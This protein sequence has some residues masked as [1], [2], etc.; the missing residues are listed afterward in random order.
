MRRSKAEAFSGA[1]VES[2]HG[3]YNLL[4]SDGIETELLGEELSDEAVHVLVGT[5]FP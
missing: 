5:A 1:M 4:S 3:E 2:M